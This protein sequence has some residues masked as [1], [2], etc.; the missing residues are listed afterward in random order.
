MRLACASMARYS[1]TIESTLS[2]DDAFAYMADFSNARHWD[3]SVDEASRSDSGAPGEGSTFDLVVR[4]GG[5]SIPMRYETLSY[6]EP[7]TRRARVAAA[8]FHLARHDHRRPRRD[9]LD[10]ALRRAA[11]VQRRG[12]AFGPLMQ[13][14]FNRT[15]RPCRRGHCAP[16]SIRESCPGARRAARGE[17]RRQLH[18]DRLS[19]PGAASTT[20]R[21]STSCALDGKTAIVTG[22]TSGLGPEAA[23]TARPAGRT[24]CVVGRD[25]EKTERARDRHRRAPS[26]PSPI[27][28]RSPN[29]ARSRDRFAATHDRLDVLVLNAGALTH[30]FTDARRGIRGHARDPGPVA[31]PR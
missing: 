13:L 28:R 27:C 30:A 24:V 6:E 12:R 7:R 19:R 16:R 8:A 17:R 3:P 22:A 14:L 18:P 5:R 15:G 10:R 21:R 11:R 23:R 31:V 29:A 2:P 1:T 4:F 20:G 9:G 25:P 26:R